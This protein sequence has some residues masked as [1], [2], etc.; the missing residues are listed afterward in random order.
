MSALGF[1]H[2]VFLDAV[3]GVWSVGRG[4]QG[5]LGQGHGESVSLIQQ[6]QD[7]PACLM[8]AAGF[9][10]TACVTS[11][12][13]LYTFGQNQYGQLG[14]GHTDDLYTP[15]RVVG[16]PP[17]RFVACG[18]HFTM[19]VGHD[20]SLWAFG[21]NQYGQLGFKAK[22][23]PMQSPA[24]VPHIQAHTVACGVDHTLILTPEGQVYGC[25]HGSCGELGRQG[26]SH[27]PTL[28]PL[29]CEVASVHCGAQFSL[30]RA[31]DGSLW[32]AGSN[33]KASLGQ[34]N[35]LG[36][37]QFSPGP[38][39]KAR[40]VACRNAHVLVIDEEHRLWGWGTNE[41]G[42]LGDAARSLMQR[43][44]VLLRNE[45]MRAA[46]A[47]FYNSVVVTK[48]DIVLVCGYNQ[49]GQLSLP[50]SNTSAKWT[51]NPHLSPDMID[52]QGTR[53]QAKSAMSN[54]QYW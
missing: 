20:F 12:G 13:D 38:P 35:I 3:G 33:E 16:L 25:G 17:I 29:P 27:T 30:I 39:I 26:T 14:H 53:C 42:Q 4:A 11:S 9:Q 8:V 51:V 45:A 5:R 23:Q 19:C 47:G 52:C 10:F 32:C 1:Q 34:S 7:L 41:F 6:I 22:T 43:E 28:I 37:N 36:R 48:D 15:H 46:M 44:P 31:V 50:S 49:H 24:L 21:D 40:V 54:Q 18:D 2:S